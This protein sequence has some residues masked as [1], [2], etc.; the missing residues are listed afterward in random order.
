MEKASDINK[1]IDKKSKKRE[2]KYLVSWLL[3]PSRPFVLDPIVLNVEEE[4]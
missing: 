2:K 3:S 1:R 4:L